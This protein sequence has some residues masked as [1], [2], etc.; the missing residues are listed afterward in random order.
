MR[1]RMV[2]PSTEKCQPLYRKDALKIRTVVL[3]KLDEC[4]ERNNWWGLSNLELVSHKQLK[5]CRQHSLSTQLEAEMKE[6]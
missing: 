4:L 3:M 1:I 5:I 6:L 2:L